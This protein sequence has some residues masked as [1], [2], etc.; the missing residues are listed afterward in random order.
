[1]SKWLGL[2]PRYVAAATRRSPRGCSDCIAC[3]PISSVRRTETP[4]D[5]SGGNG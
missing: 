2:M 1:L 5:E 4:T 3:T